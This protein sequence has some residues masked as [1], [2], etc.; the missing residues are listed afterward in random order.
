MDWTGDLF[1][2]NPIN[3]ANS[4]NYARGQVTVRGRLDRVKCKRISEERNLKSNFASKLERSKIQ[5]ELV[6][7]QALIVVIEREF[8]GFAVSVSYP[9]YQT[10]A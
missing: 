1:W 8:G 2:V 10:R 3:F 7:G 9:L 5:I 4:S 6:F